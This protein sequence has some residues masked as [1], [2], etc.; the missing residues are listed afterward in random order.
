MSLWIDSMKIL[1]SIVSC[2]WRHTVGYLRVTD[3]RWK[4][5]K[6]C[7][8]LWFR[9]RLDCGCDQVSSLSFSTELIE[10]LCSDAR[11]DHLPGMHLLFNKSCR[12]SSIGPLADHI[13]SS[14]TLV[15]VVYS[16]F[17]LT[18]L[19][20]YLLSSRRWSVRAWKHETGWIPLNLGMFVLLW[21]ASSK[22]WQPLI[23]KLVSC[24][25]RECA[26]L[27][28]QVCRQK[29]R[30]FVFMKEMYSVNATSRGFGKSSLKRSKS[31]RLFLANQ[32]NSANTREYNENCHAI[33]A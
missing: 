11:A 32:K 16:L 26:K 18:Y 10:S 24:T 13:R 15:N 14:T 1:S 7:I 20:C 33:V 8:I 30:L 23:H 29:N 5:Q 6:S 2:K 17:C 3:F 9:Q 19:V 22:T 12:L 25:R 4:S 28:V 27:I 31:F 21:S